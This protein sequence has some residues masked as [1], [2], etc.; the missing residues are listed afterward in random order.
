M[1]GTFTRA[2][3]IAAGLLAPV[4]ALAQ[5]ACPSAA[6]P[7][8]VIE[9]AET[10][11]HYQRLS[12]GQVLETEYYTDDFDPWQYLVSADGY[13]QESWG[14]VDGRMEEG[15]YETVTFRSPSGPLPRPTPGATWRGEEVVTIDGTQQ[16]VSPVT[17]IFEAE[18]TRRIG[19]C[20]YR[21]VPTRFVLD[22]LPDGTPGYEGLSEFYPDLGIAT[23]LGGADLGQ[24]P[25][26]NAPTSIS[27]RPPGPPVDALQK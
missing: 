17:F 2:T 10:I 25:A 1:T 7:V 19:P 15:T 12:T 8:I 26:L 13:V 3:A 27:T 11:V 24:R 21:V 20:S 22:P 4:A 16:T 6:D 18:T 23:F 9:N 14:M 5:G